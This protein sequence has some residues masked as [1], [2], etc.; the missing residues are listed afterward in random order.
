MTTMVLLSYPN[1]GEVYGSAPTYV[2]TSNLAERLGGR[3]LA[4]GSPTRLADHAS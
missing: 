4:Q 1:I 2:A 3:G